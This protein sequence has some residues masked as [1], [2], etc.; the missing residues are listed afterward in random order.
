MK[1][2]NQAIIDK[3]RGT[4]LKECR[5]YRHLT[6]QELARV[7]N[8]EPHYI[9]MLEK[10]DR[11]INNKIASRIGAAV[12]VNPAYIMLES[13][14][15]NLN[16]KS[17]FR[18]LPLDQSPDYFLLKALCGYGY[19]IFFMAVT[20]D[21]REKETDNEPI[22]VAMDDLISFSLNDSHCII[23]CEGDTEVHEAIITHVFIDGES[24]DFHEL[25]HRLNWLKSNIGYAF[26]KLP[27]S[28]SEKEMI[29]GAKL[30]DQYEINSSV[31]GGLKQSRFFRKYEKNIFK[32]PPD[33]EPSNYPEGC[34]DPE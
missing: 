7:V 10:G 30:A 15:I 4:R 18:T 26:K 16:T 21:Q 27:I 8:Y 12:N 28:G 1:A 5:E 31:S 11:S 32:L 13:D 20:Y 22:K 17:S 25:S 9:C 33:F 14:I 34:T 6:Q 3:K 2:E 23:K 19:E 24:Y 29:N